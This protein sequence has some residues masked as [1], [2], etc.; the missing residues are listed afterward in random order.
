MKGGHEDAAALFVESR[1]TAALL[2]VV[3]Q[4]RGSV[5]RTP[6]LLFVN[7]FATSRRADAS[8][9]FVRALRSMSHTPH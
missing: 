6:V 9:M 7:S 1:G 8:W 3:F 5:A 4:V 2:S